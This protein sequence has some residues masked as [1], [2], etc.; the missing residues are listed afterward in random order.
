MH[1][2]SFWP[3]IY[4]VQRLKSKENRKSWGTRNPRGQKVTHLWL[5]KWILVLIIA[6]AQR[7]FQPF[8]LC[9]ISKSRSKLA[10]LFLRLKPEYPKVNRRPVSWGFMECNSPY[11]E[12]LSIKYS[13]DNHNCIDY[14]TIQCHVTC[15]LCLIE[16]LKRKWKKKQ[17]KKH[18]C[19]IP[20]YNRI[21]DEIGLK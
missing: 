20:K 11:G 17:T 18:C 8:W 2:S 16:W 13:G 3:K 6:C 19:N 12:I 10:F 7:H 4:Q 14:H 1:T 15:L 9:S 5:R 21:I